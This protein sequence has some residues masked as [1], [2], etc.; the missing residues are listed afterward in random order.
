LIGR[1]CAAA[2][3]RWVK[4]RLIFRPPP[5]GCWLASLALLAPQA[6]FANGADLPP[7]IPLQAFVKPENDHVH[8]LV[9]VPLVLL[10]SFSLPKRGPGYLDLARIDDPLQ[11]AAASTSR[12]IE[13]REDGVA[14]SPDFL[15]G[16][17]SLLSDHSFQSYEAA[18]AHLQ[19]PSL[20]P[21]TDLFWNQGFFDVQ[22]DY[23]IRS[24]RSHFSIDTN[25]APE[26]GQR[27]RLQV[28][29][30]PVDGPVLRYKLPGRS[31]RVAL[32]PRWYEAAWLFIKLGFFDGFGFDRLVFLVCLV[33]PFRDFRSLLA[34]VLVSGAL[35]ALTSTAIA[36]GSASD[37]PFLAPLID[38]TLAAAAVLLAIGNV[39]APSLRRRWFVAAIVG[40]VG[41]F[42]LGQLLADTLQFAG[43]RTVAAVVAFDVGSVLSQLVTLALALATLRLLFARVLGPAL[44]LVIL[45]L[46][47][48]HMQWHAMMDSGHELLHQIGHVGLSAA[49]GVVWPWLLAALAV[50]ALA[51]FLPREFGGSPVPSLLPALLGRSGGAGPTRAN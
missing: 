38:A 23:P 43:T 49:L 50:G 37:S 1:G 16:S 46:I 29:F 8:L 18:L 32:D 41:G 24:A 19:G 26:L 5:L 20:A 17:I 15:K 28:E 10:T 51:F 40:A 31:G 13:L 35:Q 3:R 36:H 4:K 7:E 6:A 9:R 33:A 12:Q 42:G 22:L 27:L 30:L 44:G 39:A 34:V 2:D 25:I 11:R 21:D 48:G 45:S 47:L 14:L